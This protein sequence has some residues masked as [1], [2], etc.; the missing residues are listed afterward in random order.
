MKR[1]PFL[2]VL[3]LSCSSALAWAP[4][5]RVRITDQAVRLMPESLRLALDTHRRPLLSGMLEPL[6]EEDGTEHL[7]AGAGGTVEA[8]ARQAAADLADALTH[9]T[10]FDE[11][12]RRF[13]RLA[14][15]VADAGFPPSH[16]ADAGAD[17]RYRHFGP[18][19]DSRLGRIPLVFYGYADDDLDRGDFETFVTRIAATAG[20]HDEDLARA[21]AA[22]GDPPDPSAFDDRSVPFAVC[23]LSYSQTVT[24]VAQTW[25]SAWR[26][27]EGDVRRTP[28]AGTAKPA[29]GE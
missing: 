26:T 27:A 4:E 28:Y 7:P 10:P 18:F 16:G 8:A 5:T 11:I 25:L 6:V 12:A 15:F 29:G 17:S 20:A 22:A 1:A 23:S 24:H 13:G 9:P 3:I 2:F 14:H 19:C 21:Y